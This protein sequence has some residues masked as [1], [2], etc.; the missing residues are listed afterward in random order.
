MKFND[1]IVSRFRPDK[2]GNIFLQFEIKKEDIT[3]EDESVLRDYWQDGTLLSIEVE[4]FQFEEQNI[5]LPNVQRGHTSTEIEF[6]EKRQKYLD[7]NNIS[8]EEFKNKL[9]EDRMMK[10]GQSSK[11]LSDEELRKIIDTYF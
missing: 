5:G 9:I 6:W 3:R 2:F 11:D 7:E 1:V 10:E 8:K 4:K